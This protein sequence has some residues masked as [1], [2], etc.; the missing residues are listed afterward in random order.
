MS[1]KMLSLVSAAKH[2]R[3]SAGTLNKIIWTEET[4]TNYSKNGIVYK[5]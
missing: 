1:Y 4:N 5:D 3:L 2:L